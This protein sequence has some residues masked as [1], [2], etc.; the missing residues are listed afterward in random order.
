MRRFVPVIVLAIALTLCGCTNDT[1]SAPS[2]SAAS[3]DSFSETALAALRTPGL[4]GSVRDIIEAARTTGSLSFE[5]FKRGVDSYVQC[6]AGVGVDVRT[7]DSTNFGFPTLLVGERYLP[8]V[9]LTDDQYKELRQGCAST[10]Y[11][12]LASVYQSQRS[13]IDAKVARLKTYLPAL[14]ECLAAEGVSVP[15]DASFDEVQQLISQAYDDSGVLCDLKTG[16]VE[17]QVFPDD[18]WGNS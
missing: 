9:T 4:D 7:L 15:D 13:A 10:S 3:A 18:F 12:P 11:Y 6:M 14:T 5:D 17:D 8:G 2:E 1:S 16:F